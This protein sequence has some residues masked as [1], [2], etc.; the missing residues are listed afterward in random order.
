MDTIGI[1]QVVAECD[2]LAVTWDA[3]RFAVP[4]LLRDMAA[5]GMTFSGS[6][7]IVPPALRERT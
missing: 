7:R 5:E 2:R 6:N 4:Q 1:E 3:E